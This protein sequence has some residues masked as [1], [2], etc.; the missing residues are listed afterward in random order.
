MNHQN[1]YRVSI[2]LL[3]LLCFGSLSAQTTDNLN[4]KK[5]RVFT[6]DGDDKLF[7]SISSENGQVIIKLKDSGQSLTLTNDDIIQ[8]DE[9][10][11]SKALPYAGVMGGSV[12]LGSLLGVAQAKSNCGGEVSS[13]TKTKI[14][15][16]ITAVGAL[17]GA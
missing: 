14:V 7:N 15:L 13:D 11:G 4:L 2:L 10:T 12:L 1:F 6:K 3:G 9:Q 16:G 8:I 5:G 17:V